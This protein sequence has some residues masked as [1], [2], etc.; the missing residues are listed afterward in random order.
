[1]KKWV[2]V[3][4]A[5][6]IGVSGG[7]LGYLVG[8]SVSPVAGIVLTSLVAVVVALTSA[9]AGLNIGT[10][11]QDPDRKLPLR[12]TRVSVNPVPVSLLLV[13]LTAGSIV[14]ILTRT[15]NLLGTSTKSG[16]I[17]M[18]DGE[19]KARAG[20]LYG[21]EA[22]ECDDLRGISD[23][24]AL[25]ASMAKTFGGNSGPVRVIDGCGGNRACWQALIEVMCGK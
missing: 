6:C 22:S 5:A 17:G 8:L 12:R 18:S 24:E 11:P 3:R 20:V 10:S 13:G 4:K 14:G 2:S 15:H 21:A 19:Q 25:R 16:A 23:R 9:L 7:C 1:M